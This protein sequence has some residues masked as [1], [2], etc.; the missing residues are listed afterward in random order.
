MQEKERIREDGR[1]RERAHMRIAMGE[2]ENA[3]VR[4]LWL[5]GIQREG[6]RAMRGNENAYERDLWLEIIQREG[7]RAM[8][9]SENE[10]DLQLKRTREKTWRR[11]LLVKYLRHI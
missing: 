2:R 11:Q 10:W 1:Y 9:G 5:K 4:D 3:C 6:A 7:A 8:R